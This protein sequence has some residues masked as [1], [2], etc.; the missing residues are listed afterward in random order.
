MSL[1]KD[2]IEDIVLIPCSGAEYHGELARQVAIHL[3]EKS[4]ISTISSLNCM[5]IFLKNVILKKESMVEIIKNHLKHL[6]IIIINGCRTACASEIYSYL[7]IVP[8]LIISVQDIIPKHHLNLND[9]KHFENVP[10]LS[11]ITKEDIKKVSDYILN[12]LYEQL[13]YE[14]F[15]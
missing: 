2:K 5:T 15:P 4:T 8:D 7:G 13:N 14:M 3:E 9:L 1:I 12:K 10:K 6:N 11:E